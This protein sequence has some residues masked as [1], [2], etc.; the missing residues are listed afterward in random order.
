VYL[1]AGKALALFA[2]VPSPCFRMRV[3]VAGID[4]PTEGEPAAA[5]RT[6]S[7]KTKQNDRDGTEDAEDNKHL[8]PAHKIL[9]HFL[10]CLQQASSIVI[11]FPSLAA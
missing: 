1:L 7:S 5:V 10:T 3:V 4:P 11:Y 8:D 6:L 9:N 2:P